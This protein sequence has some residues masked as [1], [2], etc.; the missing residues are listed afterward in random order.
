MRQFLQ[1]LRENATWWISLTF[2]IGLAVGLMVLMRHDADDLQ[3]GITGFFTSGSSATLTEEPDA[4]DSDDAVSDDAVQPEEKTGAETE[5]KGGAAGT[6]TINDA[7]LSFLPEAARQTAAQDTAMV[8]IGLTS[9]LA[10][11]NGIILQSGLI[12]TAAHAVMSQSFKQI[13]VICG[14]RKVEA[15]LQHLSPK[16]DIALLNA[17]ECVGEPLRFATKR[18]KVNAELVVCGYLMQPNWT[19][20]DRFCRGTSVVPG[21]RPIL[22]KGRDDGMFAEMTFMG[23]KKLPGSLAIAGVLPPGSSG[24][25]VMDKRGRIVGMI[26]AIDPQPGRMQI[27]PAKTIRRVLKEQGMR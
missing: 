4:V 1:R 3:S 18:P 24:S 15:T 21:G 7:D 9:G 22:L 17:P 6:I 19:T 13:F 25:I 8:T 27:V 23:W 14:G 10:F 2:A 5:K 16:D 20:L 26:S 12:L 11:D